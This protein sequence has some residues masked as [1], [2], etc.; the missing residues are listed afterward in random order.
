[1]KRAKR[2]GADIAFWDESGF[3]AYAVHE[4][5]CSARSILLDQVG[6]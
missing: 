3:R 6:K 4:I 1:M 5:T 2:H